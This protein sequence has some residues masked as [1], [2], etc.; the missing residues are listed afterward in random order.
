[1]K[2]PK[3]WQHFLTGNLEAVYGQGCSSTELSPS[4]STQLGA[5]LSSLHI[6]GTA[7]QQAFQKWQGPN[8]IIMGLFEAE[9]SATRE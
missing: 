5:L 4:P 2:T 8:L 9:K 6:S 7:T 3:P 1:M